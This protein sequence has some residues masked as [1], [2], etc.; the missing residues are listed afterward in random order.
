[1]LSE[2]EETRK[3]IE[4]RF[5]SI[6]ERIANLRKTIDMDEF[7]PREIQADAQAGNLGFYN[8]IWHTTLEQ[9]E[10]KNYEQSL[11][12]FREIYN[13]LIQE[14]ADKADLPEKADRNY[15]D[16]KIK[17]FGVIILNQ[18][19]DKLEEEYETI[20]DQI[21][22]LRNNADAIKQHFEQ[23]SQA[24]KKE[25]SLLRKYYGVTDKEEDNVIPKVHPM[26]T[27][28]TFTPQIRHTTKIRCKSDLSPV[29]LGSPSLRR[30]L[31]IHTPYKQRMPFK[32]ELPQLFIGNAN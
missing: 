11:S 21:D 22:Q 1:M 12:S 25:I 27:T 19:Q 6:D 10:Q 4:S 26:R 29:V 2:I 7:E 16:S 24:I 18:V 32:P 15:V 31:S 14:K 17:E 13:S 28:H 8:E 23:N 20:K 9:A 30:P 3:K 5:P